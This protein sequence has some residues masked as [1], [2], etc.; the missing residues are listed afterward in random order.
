MKNLF[1]ISLLILMT[2]IF[3]CSNNKNEEAT[4]ELQQT[5]IDSNTASSQALMAELPSFDVFDIEGNIL[6]LENL[7]GKKVF[8]NLWASW[9]PPCKRE[10][11]SIAKLY[12]S[13]DTNKVA[14]V[15][16]S[17]DDKFEKAK[18]FVRSAKL[19]LPIFYPA[20]NLPALF[21]VEGIPATFI[22]DENGELIKRVDGGSNYNTSEFKTLLQ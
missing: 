18:A 4:T 21:Y 9:C 17:L 12:K 8:V 13:I 14:F 22:F 3:A 19:H 10:M 5:N 16:I 1:V 20:E 7:K 11:P 6:H 2:S 15:M